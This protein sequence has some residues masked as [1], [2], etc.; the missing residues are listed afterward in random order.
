M[1]C[2][3]LLLYDKLSSLR[4]SD[5]LAPFVR[6]VKGTRFNSIRRD[7]E[8]AF[9]PL[10]ISPPPVGGDLDDYTT[11]YSLLPTCKVH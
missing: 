11:I 2:A 8:Y 4:P 5:M 1:L 6:H 7:L 3:T 9:T 10:F